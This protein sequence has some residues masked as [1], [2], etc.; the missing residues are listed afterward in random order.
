MH[1]RTPEIDQI[2]DQFRA[3]ARDLI[4]GEAGPEALAGIATAHRADVD[5]LAIRA[6]AAEAENRITLSR[7]RTADDISRALH[8]YLTSEIIRGV[9]VAAHV[10]Q[11]RRQLDRVRAAVTNARVGDG[12]EGGA[13]AVADLDAILAEPTEHP[14]QLS[15][16]VA[17]VP[18]PARDRSGHFTSDDGAVTHGYPLVGWSLV[19]HPA[20]ATEPRRLEPT[21]LVEDRALPESTLRTTYGLHLRRLI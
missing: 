19:V 14:E 7:L 17:F 12:G 11:Y 6:H 16:V 18:E 5:R 21:F 1:T 3:R 15:T 4:E 2:S 20:P 8:G 9:R 13:V 10:E